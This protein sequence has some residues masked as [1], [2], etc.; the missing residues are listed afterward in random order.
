MDSLFRIDPSKFNHDRDQLC[1]KQFPQC[2][3]KLTVPVFLKV[4]EYSVVQL[5]VGKRRLQVDLQQK[6]LVFKHLAH[7]AAG[8]QH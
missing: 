1:R 3:F 4:P 7:M 2:I 8:R 5:L 6:L